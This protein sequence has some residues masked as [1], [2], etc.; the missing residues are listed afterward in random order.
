MAILYQVI[1]IAVE[2][3]EW[4]IIAR[5][6]LSWVNVGPNNQIAVFIY[7]MTEPILKPIRS[8]M[9]RGSLPL[10]FSPLIA[11]ILLEFLQRLILSVLF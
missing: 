2:L 7:E 10:D 8:A 11:I 6:L 4:L 9:P 5:V 3:M 1:R